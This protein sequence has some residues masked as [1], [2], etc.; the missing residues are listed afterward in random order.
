[1]SCPSAAPA[2]LQ[3]PTLQQSIEATLALLPRGRTWPANDRSIATRFLAWLAALPTGAPPAPATW[4][5]GYGQAGFFAAL[6][7]VRNYLESRLCAL[8]LEFWCATH[9]ETHDWWMQEYGLPDDCDPFPDLCVKVAALGGRRC[10]LYQAL[11]ARL[12]WLVDCITGARC[13]SPSL[14]GH[15]LAGHARASG[16]GPV[17]NIR[18]VVHLHDSPA[19]T[20]GFQTPP[21]AGR[22]LAGMPNACP[23]DI[24]PLRCLMDRIAPAHVVVNYFTV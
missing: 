22:L 2:P 14:A 21:L 9:V 10:E 12:G 16:G 18:I 19:Y 13:A 24:T 20:G 7:A 5:P 1:M 4:P 6:G 8:R 15:G 3:C 23:P 11:V 17:N